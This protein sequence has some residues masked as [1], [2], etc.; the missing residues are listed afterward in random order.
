MMSSSK[1]RSTCENAVAPPQLGDEGSKWSALF[2][3]LI[4][5]LMVVSSIYLNLQSA[6]TETATWIK[7]SGAYQNSNKWISNT[8]LNPPDTRHQLLYKLKLHS[9]L[10]NYTVLEKQWRNEQTHLRVYPLRWFPSFA[11]RIP[12]AHNYYVISIRKW[13]RARTKRKRF[14]SN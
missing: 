2:Y 5:I 1:T 7:L 4:L 12:T 3:W 11:L 8:K 9:I 13:A 14:P 10:I 6:L